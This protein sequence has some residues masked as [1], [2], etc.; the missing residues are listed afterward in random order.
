MFFMFSS[1][2]PLLPSQMRP[3][4]TLHYLILHCAG[5]SDSIAFCGVVLDVARWTL[6]NTYTLHTQDCI[7]HSALCLAYS[8]NTALHIALHARAAGSTPRTRTSADQFGSELATI[9]YFLTFLTYSSW[10]LLISDVEVWQYLFLILRERTPTAQCTLHYTLQCTRT[11]NCKCNRNHISAPNSK[12]VSRLTMCRA[13]LY[14]MF[15]I[16]SVYAFV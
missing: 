16:T 7:L 8:Q 4:L 3:G 1:P 2:S 14:V 9:T 12:L 11:C 5:G 15:C 6:H 13:V 10:K